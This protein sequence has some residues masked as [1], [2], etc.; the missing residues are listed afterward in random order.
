MAKDENK[1]YKKQ[2]SKKYNLFDDGIKKDPLYRKRDLKST[3]D[4]AYEMI[5]ENTKPNKKPLPGQLIVFN[6]NTPIWKD[7]LEYYDAQPCTIMFGLVNT[8]RGRRVLG[9]NLHYYPPKM[10]YMIMNGIFNMFKGF[11][12][13]NWETGSK[14]INKQF[15]YNSIIKQLKRYKLEFGVRMYDPKLMTIPHQVP[16]E[17]FPTAMFTEGK[18]QKKTLAYIYKY[19]NDWNKKQK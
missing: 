18:F 14:S 15:D 10:R 1:R 11:F 6:Y 17:M 13:N 9:F 4:K 8:E 2:P 5:I 7:E 3:P 12:L 16:P 19:W